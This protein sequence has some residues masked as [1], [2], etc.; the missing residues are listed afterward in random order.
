MCNVLEKYN[1]AGKK[2]N[3]KKG[4]LLRRLWGSDIERPVGCSVEWLGWL[5]CTSDEAC[6]EGGIEAPRR[7]RFLI[8]F[9]SRESPSAE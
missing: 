2:I 1:T 8:T 9:I 4:K 5:E 3:T 7:I 6:G